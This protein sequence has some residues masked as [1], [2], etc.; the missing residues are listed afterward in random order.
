MASQGR[1]PALLV[2]LFAVSAIALA[3]K[4]QASISDSGPSLVN[5][6][7]PATYTPSRTAGLRPLSIQGGELTGGPLPFFPVTPCRQYD[8]RPSHGGPGA[9]ANNTPLLVAM[10][11]GACG[12]PATAAAISLNITVF[13]ILSATGNGVFKIGIANPPTTAWINYPSS[14]T[15][16]PNAGVV[17]T[18]GS[19]N[20]WVQV[21]QGGGSVDF[22]IDVNGYYYNGNLSSMPNGDYFG[23]RGDTTVGGV[24]FAVNV[25]GSAANANGVFGAT[26]SSG[27]GSAGVV[28]S[29]ASATGLTYGVFGS[30]LS[31]SFNAAGVRGEGNGNGQ[32][33]G[34]EGTC[35]SGPP[36]SLCTGAAGRGIGGG[37]YFTASDTGGYGVQGIALATTG[38]GRGVIGREN[39]LDSDSA[40]ILGIDATGS[41]AGSTG[42]ITAG[43]RGESKGSLGV[44]GVSYVFGVQG[45]LF[46]TSGAFLAEGTLGY[47]SGSSH[48]GVYSLGSFGGTGAKYFVEPHPSDASKVI[49]YVCLEGRESGTYF[50]GSA[51]VVNGTAVIDV[52]EDFRFVTDM[53]GLTVQLTPVGELATMAVV[54]EDL[55]QIVVKS[56]RDVRFHYMVNGVRKAFKDHQAIGDGTEFMPR[57]A[58]DRMPAYLTDEASRRL[59]ANGTY[60]ADGTVN[61]ATAERLGWTKIWADRE[62]EARA[63]AAVETQRTAQAN[64]QSR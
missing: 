48:Y 54:T 56:S 15:Q 44:L 32:T 42:F 64:P 26:N 63:A 53:E 61:L 36:G 37:G 35:T 19:G 34:V 41:P 11:G 22:T 59:I 60:N 3:A 33:I 21:N 18:D 62:A 52:P 58:S 10:S 47:F 4:P 29:A 5:W 13:D 45:A 30:S 12:I 46:N 24:I 57:S 16:R 17:S 20:I 27:S 49:R 2:S 23:I 39:S 25:D 43:V 14:E 28:G 55:N 50:R 40:G 38:R 1:L 9:L 51:Q 8:S 6:W 7:A 31:T